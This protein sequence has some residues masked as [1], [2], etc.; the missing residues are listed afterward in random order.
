MIKNKKILILVICVLL[1]VIIAAAAIIIPKFINNSTDLQN[2]SDIASQSQDSEETE[3]D[4]DT[5]IDSV[6]PPQTDLPAKVEIPVEKDPQTGEEKG[7]KFPCEIEGYGLILEKVAP[8][9]GMYVEDGSNTEK[10]DVAMM[11]VRN[12]GE[13]PIEYTKIS[14]KYGDEELLFEI[15][16]L[17]LGEAVVVQ[18][19]NGKSVPDGKASSGEVL[20][21]QRAKMEMSKDMVSVKDNGDN[22]VTVTNLTKETIPTVRIFYKYYMK[23]EKVFVGGIAFTSRITR[24]APDSEI[25]IR[26]S[27]FTSDSSKIVMVLTYED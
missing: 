17:P 11:L 20:A 3:K 26:P 4:D 23:D 10:K 1:A 18:E 16:A 9:E 19:K 24:L 12:D 21:V 15:S 25:V 8:Y 7:I 22:S 13:F 5:E 6:K 14:V 27:H 2:N